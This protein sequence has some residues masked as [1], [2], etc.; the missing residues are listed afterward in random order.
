MKKLIALA[1]VLSAA[2]ALYA[3]GGKEKPKAPAAEKRHPAGGP[4]RN[5]GP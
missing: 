5:A 4:G 1:L 3:G 2:F